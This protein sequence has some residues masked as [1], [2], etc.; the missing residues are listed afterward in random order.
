[1][2][3][4]QDRYIRENPRKNAKMS[5]VLWDDNTSGYFSYNKKEE[6][7]E[8]F[9]GGNENKVGHKDVTGDLVNVVGATNVINYSDINGKVDHVK[10]Q[11][12]CNNGKAKV[13]VSNKGDVSKK[14]YDVNPEAIMNNKILGTIDEVDKIH[15]GQVVGNMS[16]DRMML[17]HFQ[18][19]SNRLHHSINNR[20][21]SHHSRVLSNDPFFNP[22]AK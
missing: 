2:N 3:N 16:F 21:I 7:V 6:V 4:Y 18:N 14:M 8:G 11:V 22:K 12:K 1:M 19:T 5:P 10:T 13:M 9:N 15:N 17:N 20:V